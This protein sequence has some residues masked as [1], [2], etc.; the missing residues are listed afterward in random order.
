M[1]LYK[2]LP[3]VVFYYKFDENNLINFNKNEY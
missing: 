3:F 2:H 1:V